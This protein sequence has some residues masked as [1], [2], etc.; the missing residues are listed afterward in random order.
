MGS[1]VGIDEVGRGCWAGPLLVVA[2]RATGELPEGLKDSKLLSKK[3]REEMFKILSLCCLFGEG[4]VKAA[5]IDRNGLA[6][7]LRIGARRALANLFAETNDEIIIDGKINYL[8]IRFTGGRAVVGADNLVP[9]V[10]AASVYAKVVRDSYMAE[11]GRKYPKYK[12][13]KNAGYGTKAHVLALKEH[14]AVKYVHRASY[15][16]IAEL[17]GA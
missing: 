16:P 4:W 2:A 10:S 7:A 9:I 12:F 3:Q 8:P 6:H 5:E 15:A 1:L 13:E 14:G 17:I 11:L